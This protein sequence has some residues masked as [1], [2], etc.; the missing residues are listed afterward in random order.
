VVQDDVVI[1]ER[2]MP[3]SEGFAPGRFRV[4]Q[5]VLNR[6]LTLKHLTGA[7]LLIALPY[8]IVRVHPVSSNSR[9]GPQ[10][11]LGLQTLISQV[12]TEL[13]NLERER[14]TRKE[15]AMFQLNAFD[16]ELQFI[17]RENS[18]VAGHG[19]FKL[20]AVDNEM[21]TGSERVQKLI[22]HMTTVPPL[23]GSTAASALSSVPQTG[24]TELIGPRP[25]PKKVRKP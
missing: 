2:R 8:V 6:P 1:G 13:S 4:A 5:A 11:E 7:L 14:L 24:E 18:R 3:E 12:K 21:Q 19:D 20:V 10:E 16:L 17:V 22:L 25:P 23:I 15:L 9:R